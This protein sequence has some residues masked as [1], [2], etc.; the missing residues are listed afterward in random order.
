VRIFVSSTFEDLREHRAA[1]IRVL[2]QLG[3]EVLAMEDMVA[4]SQTPLN[5]V[6][7]MVD[8]CEAYVGIFGWRYGYG[9]GAQY[10]APPVSSTDPAGLAVP[11]P[12]PVVKGA[13]YGET[14]I[15]HYEYLRANERSLQILAFLLDD[16]VPIPPVFVDGFDRSRPG[17]P[18]DTTRIRQLREQLQAEKVVAWFSS[19]SDLEARVAAAITSVGLSRQIDAQRAVAVGAGAGVNSVLDSGGMTIAD[20]VGEASMRQKLFQIDL[21]DTWWSTRLYLIAAL[22]ERVT[23]VRRILVVRRVE[24]VQLA[25]PVGSD[26]RVRAPVEFVGLLPTSTIIS[27]IG[28]MSPAFGRFRTWLA[29]Q[30]LDENEDPRSTAERYLHEGWPRS[31]GSRGDPHAAERRLAVDVN[32]DRLRRWFGDAM[33]QQAVEVRELGRAS[34]VDVLRLVDYPS[35]FV[36]V[37]SNR[38][39]ERDEPTGIIDVIDKAAL[40]SRLARS[41]FDELKE[42]ARIT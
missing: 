18:A 42:Q 40:T 6:I 4:G 38:V 13:T 20:A 10:D 31:L 33:L 27:T 5:R 14:S 29:S 32:P 24:D 28:P 26:A 22:A 35:D 11:V 3:H 36:P 23:N 34:V 7:E 17:A 39:L 37:L 30:P 25:A 15:T 8:R 19:P 2:R 21:V 16:S 12:A 9:P 1:A 41:Y